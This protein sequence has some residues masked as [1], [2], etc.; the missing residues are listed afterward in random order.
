ML[1]PELGQL[2]LSTTCK[3]E[4]IEEKD[5]RLVLRERLGEAQFHAAGGRQLEIGRLD[6]YLEHAESLLR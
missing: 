4:D 1:R 6:A 2:G 5:E 3:V